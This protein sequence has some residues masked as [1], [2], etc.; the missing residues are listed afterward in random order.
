MGAMKDSGIEW[1]G[2]IPVEWD[3][4]KLKYCSYLKGRIGW[5][6]LRA[7]E[8]TE[9]GPY[10][11]TG[12]D[13]EN[14]RIQF[15]RSYHITEERYAEAPQIQLRVGDLLITKD[16]T[17]GKMALVTELPDKASLNSH[18]LLIRPLYEAFD[19]RYLFWLMNS[20]VFVEYTNFEQ[21]GTIMASLSQ[22]KIGNFAMYFPPIKEQQAIAK[23]LDKCCVQIDDVIA[24]IK[25]Q[26]ELLQQYKKSLI[27]E[28]VTQ[29]L[30]KTVRMKDSGIEWIGYIPHSW[31]CSKLKYC[32]TKIGSGKTP[33][34][35]ADIYVDEGITFVRSQNVYDD[36]LRLEDVK[37]I[38]KATHCYMISTELH[39]GDI[40]FNITGASIARCCIYDI[41]DKGNVNQHVCIIRL[42]N[43]MRNEYIRYVMNSEIGK[44][45][46][47]LNQMGGNRESLTFEQIG[48]FNIPIPSIDEQNAIV[49][50]LDKKCTQIDS[51][52]ESKQKQL[53]AIMEHKKSLIY[54]YVTGK[55]RVKEVQ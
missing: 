3:W 34:G 46:T 27:T 40:L 1:I 44:A 22:E 12:T 26:I 35:G 8:F 13:F 21:S 11:I 2:E 38:D 15:D 19:N 50:F 20:P 10:L 30:D 4:L 23:L 17:V 7:E 54:E 45:Q 43:N 42:N 48:M 47:K 5:Q 6:G 55:K 25:K 16:G 39:Y 37:Y 51:I 9:E 33:K 18:L 36:G 28:T 32:S 14:G 29:G 53:D 41:H 52:L 24:D 49:E 31:N